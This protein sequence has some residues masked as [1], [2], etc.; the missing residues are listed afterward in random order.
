M[1]NLVY[2]GMAV[3]LSLVGCLFL[4][5]RNRKPRSMEAH[6]REFAREMQALAPHHPARPRPPAQ[7]PTGRGRRSG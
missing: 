6:I 5:L 7:P 2:L 4:W 3:V 1:S